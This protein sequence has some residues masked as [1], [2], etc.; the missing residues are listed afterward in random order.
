MAAK[1][2]SVTPECV[3]LTGVPQVHLC[4]GGP[5]CP[6]DITFP[7]CLRA[8]LEF[9]GDNLGCRHLPTVTPG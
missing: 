7:F 2:K 8:A 1:A 5:R 4:Q 6:E 3:L 9:L